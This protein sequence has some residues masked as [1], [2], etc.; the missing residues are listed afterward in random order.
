MEEYSGEGQHWGCW[1][2]SVKTSGYQQPRYWLNAY[3]TKTAPRVKSPD[4]GKYAGI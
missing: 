4:L 2:T 1:Y 3:I